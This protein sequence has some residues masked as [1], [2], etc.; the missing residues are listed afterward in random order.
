MKTENTEQICIYKLIIKLNSYVFL[1]IFS[2][3]IY[4]KV[5]L[6][7]NVTRDNRKLITLE[8]C[9]DRLSLTLMLKKHMSRCSFSSYIKPSQMGTFNN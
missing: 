2:K 8:G 9:F 5:I 1:K 4:K 3:Q 7:H 6:S